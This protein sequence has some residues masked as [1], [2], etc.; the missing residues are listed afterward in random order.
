MILPIIGMIL[1][2]HTLYQLLQALYVNQAEIGVWMLLAAVALICLN[3][4][5]LSCLHAIG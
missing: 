2:Y 3:L 5:F 4:S 1:L